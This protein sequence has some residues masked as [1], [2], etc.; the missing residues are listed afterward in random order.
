VQEIAEQI[1]ARYL[2]NRP[3]S[4]LAIGVS[5][6]PEHRYA[7][8]SGPRSPYAGIDRHSLFEIGSVS[9][10]FAAVLLEK[11]VLAGYTEMTTP[12]HEV[13]PELREIIASSMTV[14]QLAVH[15][16]GLP[17]DYSL[18][19]TKEARQEQRDPWAMLTRDDL[20][21]YL[22]TAKVGIPGSKWRYSNIGYSILAIGLEKI[23]GEEYP[24]L[25][26]QYVFEP[27]QMLDSVS[28]TEP[29]ECATQGHCGKQR[30]PYSESALLYGPGDIRASVHDMLCYLDAAMYP[31]RAPYQGFGQYLFSPT[32]DKKPRKVRQGLGWA[33]IEEDRGWLVIANGATHGF[34][35]CAV[36]SPTKRKSV[37]VLS[38]HVDIGGIRDLLYAWLRKNS[39]AQG[40]T[41]LLYDGL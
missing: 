11:A 20:Y 23:F 1:F 22:A 18:Q 7:F 2:R 27:L 3:K 19:M 32:E 39:T 15:T 40:A 4:D 25:L 35:C 14:Q 16:S 37:V 17:Y 28:T 38:N 34:S 24:K 26:Q 12:V 5:Y 10:T 8:L 29:I 33:L 21:A 36:F 41:Q 30:S 9:K 13:V 6:G 31:D